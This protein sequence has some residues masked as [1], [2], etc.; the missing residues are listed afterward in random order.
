MRKLA[1]FVEGQ[2]E[3]IFV[4]RLVLQAA[5]VNNVAIEKVQ[6]SGGRKGARR[7]TR[8]EAV[9]W[10]GSENYYVLLCDCGADNRVVSDIREQY[11]SLSR[12]YEGIVG[13]RDLYPKARA[14]L[15]RVVTAMR[16]HLKTDPIRVEL[17]IAV[18]ETEAWFL[19]E[20]TH[21]QRIDTSLT[22]PRITGALGFD[23]TE[24][25]VEARP[26]PTHDLDAIY[27]LA[28]KSYMKD[29]SSVRQTV[30]A[31]DYGKLNTDVSVRVPSL[32][33]LTGCLNRFF[34]KR[35]VTARGGGS[36]HPLTGAAHC[37]D[38]SKG[39]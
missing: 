20:F 2:T 9:D 1:V 38:L 5:G 17:V 23:L 21:F 28:G 15:C 35:E 18:V 11:D 24:V 10:A 27:S 13:I 7:I 19:G 29:R 8:I 12:D 36:P 26:R 39:T 34:G 25:D 30:N 32:R 37:P 22:L 14:D 3:Q 6:A 16:A 33:R 4:E 31:L